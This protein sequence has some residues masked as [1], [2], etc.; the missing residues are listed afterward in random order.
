LDLLPTD[1]PRRASI[2]A[3]LGEALGATGHNAAAA[4]ACLA[5]CE[6][7]HGIEQVGLR[8]AA[9]EHLLTCGRLEEG[10]AQARKTL[11]LLDLRFPA[12]YGETLLALSLRLFLRVWIERDIALRPGQA[13][14]MDQMRVDTCINLSINFALFDPLRS[15]YFRKL[16]LHEAIQVGEPRLVLRALLHDATTLAAQ[17]RGVLSP[18]EQWVRSWVN[19][20][21]PLCPGEELFVET[22]H[23]V[24]SY[25]RGDAQACLHHAECVDRGLATG[26]MAQRYTSMARFLLVY[27]LCKTGHWERFRTLFPTFLDDARARDDSF[28]GALLRASLGHLFALLEDRPDDAPHAVNSALTDL[29]GLRPTLLVGRLGA[30]VDVALYRGRGAEAWASCGNLDLTASLILRAFR[31]LHID[32]LWA[33]GRA[34]LGA[35]SEATGAL[36]RYNLRRQLARVEAE[37]AAQGTPLALALAPCLRGALLPDREAILTLQQ[38][39]ESLLTLGLQPIALALQW[40]LGALTKDTHLQ[41]QALEETRDSGVQNPGPWLWMTLPGSRTRALL[42]TS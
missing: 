9:T 1:D 13:T 31:V 18:R 35:L 20:L 4:D 32:V 25:L 14:P 17:G 8:V 6:L 26:R 15:A 39:R 38:A 36:Q 11:E 27:S 12:S 29:P 10:I 23:A 5:A 21:L 28:L 7:S 42:H 33:R 22:A 24:Q 19:T 41:R 37:L 3:R 30:S 2:L 40:H 16:A 34:L